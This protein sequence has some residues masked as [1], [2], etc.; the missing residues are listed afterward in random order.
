MA[1]IL[2]EGL[3]DYDEPINIRYQFDIVTLDELSMEAQTTEY[4]V[5]DGSTKQENTVLPPITF[6]LEGF[7]AEKVFRPSLSS[8]ARKAANR[9]SKLQPITALLPEVS[10]YARTAVMAAHAAETAVRRTINNIKGIT[11]L[12]SGKAG[13]TTKVQ[14]KVAYEL[15]ALRDNLVLVTVVSD[16]GVYE[17]MRIKSVNMSQ[18]DTDG[19]SRLRV[20]L[21]QF[22]PV[23]TQ[24]TT[25]DTQKYNGRV[26][27][28]AATMQN[29]GKIQ[30][31]TMST[32]RS[33]VSPNIVPYITGVGE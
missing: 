18:E 14:T 25:I 9:L 4:V 32:L 33:W 26:A 1:D 17:N 27:Q 22:N 15:K 10:S 6:T 12:W 31:K 30:G 23:S 28:Q 3:I 5:E 24:L 13:V 11:K 29:L 8:L 20:E 21:Q 2:L 16:L 7:V 19:Q